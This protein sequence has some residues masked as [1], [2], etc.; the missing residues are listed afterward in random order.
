[1]SLEGHGLTVIAGRRRIL[2]AVDIAVVP[3]QVTA[4]VGPNGAGKSTLLK[5]LSGDLVSQSG[6]VVLNGMPLSQWSAEER[7]LQRAVLPQSPELAFPFRAW[8]VV[9]LGRHPHR[10][11]T[12]RDA[13]RAAITGAMQATEL[14][15]L[16]D[17][18]CRTLSG[19]EL[20]RT[21]YARTLAQIWEPL[22][23]GRARF[24]LLDEPTSSLDLFHQHAILAKAR[25]I[26]R[27]GAGVLAVL[28]D[29][30]L[31]AAYADRVAVLA[32][33]RIDAMGVPE[34]VLTEERIARVWRVDCR[35]VSSAAG[36]IQLLITPRAHAVAEHA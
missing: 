22:G 5:V 13:D 35:V 27:A 26:A 9:E 3:G 36:T 16:A 30:N 20:H 1:M 21:H 29:L 6:R 31:A 33:G 28:H 24:L 7:A 15:T 11:R 23:D 32:N 18:D 25:D 34:Q 19:G 10:K 2:D 14:S 8:D 4:V 17:R 12:T